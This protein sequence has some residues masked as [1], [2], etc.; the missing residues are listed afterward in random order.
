MVDDHPKLHVW[1]WIHSSIG[2]PPKGNED[3]IQRLCKANDS[4]KIGDLPS[5]TGQANGIFLPMS[6]M[7]IGH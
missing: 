3:P 2:K 4:K 7:P 1:W 5:L 6:G